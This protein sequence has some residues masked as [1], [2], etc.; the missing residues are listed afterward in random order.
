VLHSRSV[1]NRHSMTF[2]RGQGGNL[3]IKDAFEFVMSM[4]AVQNGEQTLEQATS[5]YDEGVLVRGEEV[6]ISKSQAAAFHDYANFKN[7][8]I[9]KMG[10]KPAGS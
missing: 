10:I 3:A 5:K 8:P 1:I 6:E 4:L 9:F 7:S 2:H